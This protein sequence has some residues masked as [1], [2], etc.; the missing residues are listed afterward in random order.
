MPA[1]LRSGLAVNAV[2]GAAL[3]LFGYLAVMS[4]TG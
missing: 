2:L 3:I 1:T 4:V